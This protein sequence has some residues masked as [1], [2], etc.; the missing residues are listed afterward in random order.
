MRQIREETL[1]LNLLEQ[2]HIQILIH[3]SGLRH[4]NC[5]HVVDVKTEDFASTEPNNKALKKV[6]IKYHCCAF[7]NIPNIQNTAM[8]TQ[9]NV[10]ARAYVLP[11][12]FVDA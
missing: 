9:Q 5:G 1:C 8:T 10:P 3:G 4:F 11:V 12:I 7:L 6:Y 2:F